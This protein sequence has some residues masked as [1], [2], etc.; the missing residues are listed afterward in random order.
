M[1]DWTAARTKVVRE[2]TCRLCNRA[3]TLEAA[4]VI[5]RS[6]GG[7]QESDSTIP[8]CPH[9][10]RDYDAG[11][12][13]LLPVL[14]KDEQAEAVRLVGLTRALAIISPEFNPRR[15]A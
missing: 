6:L 5:P 7:G 12:A 14:T 13:D 10:H 4:H 2:G 9:C 1:R 11:A 3:G 15:A 8:L